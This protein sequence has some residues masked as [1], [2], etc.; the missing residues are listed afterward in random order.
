MIIDFD[1]DRDTE[2]EYEE[3]EESVKYDFLNDF[4]VDEYDIVLD[5]IK[6]Y[7]ILC[8]LKDFV[9]ASENIWDGQRS[10][11]NIH[12]KSLEKDIESG[13]NISDTFKIIMLEDFSNF[14]LVDGQHRQKACI[15]I[16][17]KYINFNPTIC[18]EIFITQ[19]FNAEIENKIYCLINNRLEFNN[20]CYTDI[21]ILKII[22]MFRKKY[23]LV[24]SNK[25]RCNR[26]YITIENFKKI[27]KSIL[28]KNPNISE[29]KVIENINQL[30]LEH[31]LSRKQ[32]NKKLK[33]KKYT[34]TINLYK[35][36][37]T[38]TYFMLG[39]FKSK[40]WGNLLVKL[41]TK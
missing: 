7:T 23:P 41:S 33:N 5:N 11:D 20:E 37:T 32:L 29:Q 13:M 25:N 31:N 35:T 10:I 17:K 4:V 27:L 21:K 39:L 14:K 38:K 22:D 36:A 15:N 40:Y 12:V 16:I 3:E 8:R 2:T 6:K 9:Y 34:I 24:L 19:N 28:K 30:N 18:V 26:P 1:S